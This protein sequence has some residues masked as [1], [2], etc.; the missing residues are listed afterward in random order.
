MIIFYLRNFKATSLK[1]SF[2]STCAGS[3]MLTRASWRPDRAPHRDPHHLQDLPALPHPRHPPTK[4][5]LRAAT[6]TRWESPKPR[7]S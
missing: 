7:G 5:R 4:S 3:R 1:L 2:L 6:S